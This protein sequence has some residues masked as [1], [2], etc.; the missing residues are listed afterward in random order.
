MIRVLPELVQY[1]KGREIERSGE[2]RKLVEIML[3]RARGDNTD[4]IRQ[5]AQESLREIIAQFGEHI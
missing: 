2:F 3:I 5:Q 4:S 1:G